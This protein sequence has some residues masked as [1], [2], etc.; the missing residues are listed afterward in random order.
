MPSFAED[1]NNLVIDIMG[2]RARRL[3]I[4]GQ[5]LN[6]RAWVLQERAFA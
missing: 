4:S 3:L 6:A 1:V 5:P 2:F